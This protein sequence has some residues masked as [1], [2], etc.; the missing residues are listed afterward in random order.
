MTASTETRPD[1]DTKPDLE[2]IL[3]EQGV[4]VVVGVPCRVKR[5]KLREMMLLARVLTAGVGAN[6]AELRID[7]EE[8][9]EEKLMALLVMAIPEAGPETCDLFAALVEPIRALE[10]DTKQ[11]TGKVLLVTEEMRNPDPEVAFDILGIVAA[12][13][14][15]TFPL[16]LGKARAVFG[17]VTALYRT[18]KKGS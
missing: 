11:H 7:D 13:E 16:L 18:G 9:F 15:D 10:D 3:P 1:D 6:L 14:K 12:Q 8:G 5:I 4:V 2:V 17:N